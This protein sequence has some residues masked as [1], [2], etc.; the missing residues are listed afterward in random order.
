MEMNWSTEY[1]A[2]SKA[3]YFPSAFSA[4]N[5]ASFPVD[6]SSASSFTHPTYLSR[7]TGLLSIT[8][9]GTYGVLWGEQPGCSNSLLPSPLVSNFSVFFSPHCTPDLLQ[10]SMLLFPSHSAEHGR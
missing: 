4:L 3:V 8:G 5:L 2:R 1:G 7:D 10:I 9:Q 6:W